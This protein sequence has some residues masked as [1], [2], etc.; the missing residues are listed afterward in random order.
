MKRDKHV[1]STELLRNTNIYLSLAPECG[2]L[3]GVDN[4]EDTL[5]PVDPVDVVPKGRGLEQELLD[6]LPEVDVGA[7]SAGAGAGT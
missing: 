4:L 2:H 5:L 1:S 6:E 3:D 7:R